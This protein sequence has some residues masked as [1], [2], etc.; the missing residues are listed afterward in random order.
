MATNDKNDAA[1]NR[2]KETGVK[3][4]TRHEAERQ[5]AQTNDREKLTELAGHPNS[6]VVKSAKHKLGKLAPAA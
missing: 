2:R 6:H 4:L 3:R 1:S 5:V